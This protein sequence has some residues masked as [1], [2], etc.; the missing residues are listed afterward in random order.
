MMATTHSHD[1]LIA[2]AATAVERYP[3][4]YPL[5]PEDRAR[6]LESLRRL[7]VGLLAPRVDPDAA[8][9]A[10][11][12]EATTIPAIPRDPGGGAGILHRGQYRGIRVDGEARHRAPCPW[13][14]DPW[15]TTPTGDL[16]PCAC[17]LGERLEGPIAGTVDGAVWAIERDL[18][19]DELAREGERWRDMSSRERRHATRRLERLLRERGLPIPWRAGPGATWESLRDRLAGDLRAHA[20]ERGS[21]ALAKLAGFLR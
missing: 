3:L 10:P 16:I 17:G 5:P 12:V 21:N 11:R 15:P 1:T 4:L 18:L 9:M 14:R 20:T 13:T 8:P 6:I 19:R 7:R 2:L